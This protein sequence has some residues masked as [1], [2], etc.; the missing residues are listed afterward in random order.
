MIHSDISN[1]DH[2]DVLD[3]FGLETKD[4]PTFV[5]FHLDSTSKYKP[6][7]PTDISIRNMRGF[8]RD[9]L[10]GKI[11]KFAKSAELPDNWNDG[12]VKTLVA[13]NFEKVAKDVNKNVF[14]FYYAPWSSEYKTI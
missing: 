6:A 8:V 2:A 9:Y 14:V 12:N 7:N 3:Y 11:E 5:L 4:C 10:D 1:E 13:A